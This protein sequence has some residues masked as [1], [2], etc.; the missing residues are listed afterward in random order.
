MKQHVK[1]KPPYFQPFVGTINEDG[2]GRNRSR[3]IQLSRTD[4]VVDK[5]S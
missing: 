5:K 1:Q 4:R 3:R 2:F